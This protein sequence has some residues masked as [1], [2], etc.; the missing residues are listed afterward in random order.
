MA[1]SMG[2][3]MAGGTSN[4]LKKGHSVSDGVDDAVLKNLEAAKGLAKMVASSLGPNGMNKLVINHLNKTIVTSDCATLVKELEV[5]HP[6]ASIL[7]LASQMQD[8]EFGDAT[9]LTVSFAGELLALAEDLLRQGLHTSEIVS[10]YKT[11]HEHVTKLL[12]SLVC[13]TCGDV[14][15][16]ELLVPAIKSVLMAKQLGYEDVLSNLVA[17]AAL[18]VIPTDGRPRM[19]ADSVRVVKLIGGDLTQSCVVNGMLLPRSPEGTV[20]SVEN[21]KIT[22]FQC[23]LESEGTETQGTVLIRNAEDMMSYNKSE[24]KALEEVIAAIH[25]TGTNV[26][27]TGGTVSEMALH[28]LEK[29]G[30]M[31]VKTPSKWDIRRLCATVGATGLVR[32]GPATP[33]EMGKCNK[34]Y[35]KEFGSKKV[36]LFEQDTADET[37]VASIVLRSSVVSVINDLERACEDGLAC[38]QHMCSDAPDFVAGG[39]ASEMEMASSLRKLAD[40]TDSLD[41]YAI[42]KFG[43]A[44]ECIPRVLADNSGQDSTNLVSALY[45][46]HGKAGGTHLGVDIEGANIKAQAGK[47]AGKGVKDMAASGVFDLLSTKESA[48]RLAVDAA[49]TILRVDQIIMSKPAG[50]PKS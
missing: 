49:L 32:M 13:H 28:Y 46:V 2:Y 44:F 4:M 26:V 43:E 48:I 12:P 16:K 17:D 7:S 1:K 11:A 8:Q 45:A 42:R 31:V 22:V 20:L 19:K 30:M 34:V 14:R 39:G 9:N 38:V 50:G 18:A 25:A 23:A 33:E 6:A 37:Q 15:D 29:Y 36:V 10:G 3:N 41:Q 24:E 27:I 40:D 21:A 47:G 5:A 35:V